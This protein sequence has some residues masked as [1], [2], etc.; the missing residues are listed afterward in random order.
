VA[1]VK[2][3]GLDTPLTVTELLPPAAEYPE[4]TDAH[5][6]DYES[7]LDAFTAGDWDRAYDLLRRMPPG[8]RVP[9]FLTALIVRRDRR[10][11]PGWNGVVELDSKA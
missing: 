11:P 3:Y 8:D 7:A 6:A 4:L 10:P 2:P 9:D 5:L 1:R